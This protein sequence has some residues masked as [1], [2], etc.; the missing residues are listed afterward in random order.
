MT[1]MG[2]EQMMVN[3]RGIKQ[4][5]RPFRRGNGSADQFQS[6]IQR[7]AVNAPRLPS[8]TGSVDFPHVRQDLIEPSPAEHVG[9]PVGDVALSD[10]VKR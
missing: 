4:C 7:R 8:G 10:T 2:I 3:T 6:I 1:A 9:D 5:A